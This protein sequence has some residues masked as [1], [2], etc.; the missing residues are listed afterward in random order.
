MCLGIPMRVLE[1]RDGAGEGE[2]AGVRRPVRLD[3]VPAAR[4]GDW[5]LVHAGYALQVLDPAAAEETLAALREVGEIGRE[6]PR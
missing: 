3:L 6:E 1:A 5:V 2:L 4:P